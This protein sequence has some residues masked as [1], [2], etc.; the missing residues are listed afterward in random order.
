MWR[1]SQALNPSVT[2]PPSG[3]ASPSTLGRERDGFPKKRLHDQQQNRLNVPGYIAKAW[4][5]YNTFRGAPFPREMSQSEG[6]CTNQSP[7]QTAMRPDGAIVVPVNAT[8]TQCTT[9]GLHLLH[10][11]MSQS[12]NKTHYNSKFG[13]HLKFRTKPRFCIS[14][15]LSHRNS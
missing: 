3:S 10:T 5:H 1:Q 2:P 13:L 14:S 9:P 8:R 11:T 4:A 15:I 12:W 6:N 7:N